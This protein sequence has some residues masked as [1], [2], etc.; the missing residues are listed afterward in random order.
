MHKTST[1]TTLPTFAQVTFA[2]MLLRGV[3]EPPRGHR[4]KRSSAVG[5]FGKS[6]VGALRQHMHFTNVPLA[7][8]ADAAFNAGITSAFA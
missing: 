3:R 4:T 5:I 1:R 7:A 8:V 6:S 2:A